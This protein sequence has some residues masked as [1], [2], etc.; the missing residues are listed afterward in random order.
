MQ[1]RPI[2]VAW[3]GGK[4]CL[5][6][7][8]RLLA[9]PAWTVLGLLTT[10]DRTSD[11]V[12]MHD[13]AAVVARAQ[14][15]SLGL[16]LIE[17]SM[18]WPASNDCY[19]AALSSALEQSRLLSPSVMHIAFGDIFLADVRAWRETSLGRLGWSAI[20]PLW[21]EPSAKLARDF[22]AR[23]HRAVITTIDLEQ[24]DDA[25]CGREFDSTL[26]A[27]LPESIDPCGENGE[28]HT[29]CHQ[30]PLFSKSLSLGRGPTDTRDGRFRSMK[31]SLR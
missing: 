20:F 30:S 5:M 15:A 29:L 22:L 3:S 6:A 24:M 9:D 17:M 16:P 19:E 31:L 8:D 21:K 28:F 14:A 26:L 27:E 4:D 25:F 7:L 1:A 13:F 12:A 11:R 2:L 10:L 23:G 18:D